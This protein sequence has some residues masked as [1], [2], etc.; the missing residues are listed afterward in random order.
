M[1]G[2]AHSGTQVRA[3]SPSTFRDIRAGSL[4]EVPASAP[5]LL[6]PAFPVR[7]ALSVV[8]LVHSRSAE[9]LSDAP[10]DFVRESRILHCARQYYATHHRRD[11]KDSSLPISTLGEEHFL[12][13]LLERGFEFRGRASHFL[14]Q[15]CHGAAIAWI[16][17]VPP[18][19]VAVCK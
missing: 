14:S 4:P 8:A 19:Q 17:P 10:K 13:A 11:L 18:A 16:I 1:G 2:R 3:H 6:S 9:F 15:R 5:A 7:S 12:K